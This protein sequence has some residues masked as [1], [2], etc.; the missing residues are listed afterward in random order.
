VLALVFALAG[1]VGASFAA[2]IPALQ[3][4]LDLSAGE[5]GLAFLALEAGAVVGLPGGGA[6]VARIGSRASLRLGFAVFGPALAAVALAPS[7]AALAAALAVMAAANS[8]I[9]VAMN[10]QGVEAERRTGR[11]VMSRLHGA[12]SLG[13]VAGG[14]GGT[15]APGASVLTVVAVAV[16]VMG[17][18]A[19]ARLTA[20]PARPGPLL[21]WPRGPLLTLGTIA[22]CAFLIEGAAS[23]WSA[24]HLRTEHDASPTL[25][26]AAFT[27]FALALAVGRMVGGRDVRAASLLAAA[28]IALAIVAPGPVVAL[29]GWAILGL[30]I[31]IVAPTVMRG[32]GAQDVPAPVGIAAVTTVGYLGSFTAPPVI[33][34]LAGPIGLNAA[35][36][37]VL[38]AALYATLASSGISAS[39]WPRPGR[40]R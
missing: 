8:V 9:D 18:F 34:A 2:R 33:G 3:D 14:L 6:L 38:V 26:A 29:A 17:Q 12:H 25:A 36:L 30:G 5:L 20:E 21:A 35:L 15:L 23:N 19:A 11:S 22:F 13:V 10:T 1:L 4:R 37:V 31:S 24:V 7:L 39:T 28:G 40:A 27:A 32:A 16:L